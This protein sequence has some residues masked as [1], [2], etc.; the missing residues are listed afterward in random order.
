[1]KLFAVTSYTNYGE[2]ITIIAAEN[3]EEARA[4]VDKDYGV[5]QDYDIEEINTTKK[6]KVFS[7]G[8]D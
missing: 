3:E 5:W 2:T 8:G 7:G 4:F 6:G 1:M